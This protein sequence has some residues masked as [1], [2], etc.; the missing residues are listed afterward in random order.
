M[1]TT[2]PDVLEQLQSDL[3]VLSEGCERVRQRITAITVRR[4]VFKY[5]QDVSGQVMVQED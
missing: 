2:Q 3:K 5:I 4:E 1:D